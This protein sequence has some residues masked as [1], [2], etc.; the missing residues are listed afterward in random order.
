MPAENSG[1]FL[2]RG[3]PPIDWLFGTTKTI[4][5]VGLVLP[6]IGPPPYRRL[7]YLALIQRFTWPAGAYTVIYPIGS[8]WQDRT[9]YF[10][11]RNPTAIGVRLY[12]SKGI[13][14]ITPMFFLLFTP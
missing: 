10:L 1:S 4:T 13:A 11:A 8:I 14:D 7:G 12:P 2:F 5:N 6:E 3:G 9:L